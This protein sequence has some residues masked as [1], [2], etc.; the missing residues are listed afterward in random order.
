MIISIVAK[1]AFDKIQQPTWLRH[2]RDSPGLSTGV[3]CHFPLQCMKAKSESEVAQSC[4]TLSDP[5]D[6]S[7]PGSSLPMGFSR[8]EYWSGLPLPSPLSYPTRDQTHVPCIGRWILN[9]WTIR[10]V[11]FKSVS[12]LGNHSFH[13]SFNFIGTKMCMLFFFSFF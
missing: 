3:G 6:C 5:M 13:P 12:C 2:P 1:K 7:L 10:A 9:H 4:L 8:Q 11:Y